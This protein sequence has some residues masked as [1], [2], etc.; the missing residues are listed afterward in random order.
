M[1]ACSRFVGIRS[2]FS[3][4]K[5]MSK[6]YGVLKLELKAE[7]E[8]LKESIE[9]DRK[10]ARKDFREVRGNMDFINKM[11]EEMKKKSDGLKGLKRT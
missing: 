10:E 11:F 6:L 1:C 8:E 9:R 4:F 2:S 3:I 7:L 5:E